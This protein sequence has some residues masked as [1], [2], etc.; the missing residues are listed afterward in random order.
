[1]IVAEL[2][3]KEVKLVF[4]HRKSK[5]LDKQWMDMAGYI[6]LGILGI[7]LL[8]IVISVPLIKESGYGI[9]YYEVPALQDETIL[10]IDNERLAINGNELESISNDV[11][12]VAVKYLWGGFIV[13]L[14][15]FFSI[16]GMA[17][18]LIYAATRFADVA[19]AVYKESGKILEP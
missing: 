15:A 8:L 11:D 3:E 6:M 16:F 2:N 5:K 17:L 12:T 7:A 19:F 14:V 13:F 18:Y 9:K 1:M 10:V 4:K